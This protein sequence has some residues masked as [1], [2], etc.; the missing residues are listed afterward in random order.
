[1]PPLP[2][3]FFMFLTALQTVLATMNR[4]RGE[5]FQVTNTRDVFVVRIAGIKKSCRIDTC[6]L[7]C[8]GDQAEMNLCS[9]PYLAADLIDPAVTCVVVDE[10]R[11]MCDDVFVAD[12]CLAEMQSEMPSEFRL[13]DSCAV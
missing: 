12:L 3:L 13:V 2:Q 9:M 10:C 11:I 4:M 6:N 8:N 7:I 5:D 1:M